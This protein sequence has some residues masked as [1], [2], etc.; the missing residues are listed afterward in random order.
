MTGQE[1]LSRKEKTKVAQQRIIDAFWLLAEKN[2]LNKITVQMIIREAQ[3]ARGLFYRHFGSMQALVS[4]VIEDELIKEEA[5]RKLLVALIVNEDKL[6]E[7]MLSGYF[8]SEKITLLVARGG[9][10]AVWLTLV[11]QFN[12]MLKNIY[13]VSDKELKPEALEALWLIVS[14]TFSMLVTIKED[15][16][17]KKILPSHEAISV[18]M[19][20]ATV[21]MEEICAIQ[22]ITKHDLL[23]QALL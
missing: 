6:A 20:I 5:L 15:G 7:E 9:F 10:K 2:D 16:T 3:C 12:E 8:G 14:S 19:K 21:V 11:R 22:G 1:M 23:M 13:G 18:Y 4:H 17:V